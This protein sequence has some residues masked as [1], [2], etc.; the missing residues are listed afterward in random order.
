MSKKDIPNIKDVSSIPDELVPV[1]QWW[2]RNGRKASWIATL[3]IAAGALLYWV[4]DKNEK[5]Q[6]NTS[7]GFNLAT[8]MEE[9]KANREQGNASAVAATI[10]E[11]RALNANGEYESALTLCQD[12]DVEDAALKDACMMNK[13]IALEGLKR[14]DEAITAVDAVATDSFLKDEATFTKARLLCQKGDK[15]A[16][17]ALIAPLMDSHPKAQLLAN[18]IDA[19]GS[20]LA[21]PA[22]VVEA[23]VAPTAPEAPAP[24]APVAPAAPA[25]APATPAAPVAQ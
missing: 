18:I 6:D 16:A 9:F 20:P 1:I 7:V 22:P 21:E 3:V 5:E 2:K 12:L 11:A 17:K 23:P 8:T 19:Y 15:V 24:E 14:Y 10:A 4:V 13:A 25:P